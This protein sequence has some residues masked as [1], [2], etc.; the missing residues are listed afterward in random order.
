MVTDQHSISHKEGIMLRW[1][2]ILAMMLIPFLAPSA[3]FT[4]F[5]PH[6][7]GGSQRGA[8]DDLMRERLELQNIEQRRHIREEEFRA[9]VKQWVD[10]VQ[11]WREM[12]GQ[13][14]LSEDQLRRKLDQL[15][16][17]DW[18]R[19]YQEDWVDK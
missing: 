8:Q 18:E 4:Q 19:Q 16:V 12:T 10:T 11:A 14:L 13:P 2:L 15:R 7:D 9:E 1:K 17:F 3:G 6:V 5:L